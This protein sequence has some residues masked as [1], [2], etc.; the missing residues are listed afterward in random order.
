MSLVDVAGSLQELGPNTD[1]ARFAEMALPHLDAAYN[2]A[3]WL[4]RDPADA[5]DVV[6]E[7]ML[8][9]LR[10][11][12]S[13]RGGS[14]GKSWLLTI[15]RNTAIDWMRANRPAQ[16]MVPA[17]EDGDPFENIPAEGDDPEAA[18]IRIGDRQ[19]LDRL[20]AALPTD[21]RECLVLREMEELSYKEIAAVTG[22]PIGTV[23]SR[24]SRARLLMQ[25][26]LIRENAQ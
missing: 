11:F 24:L 10:F 25:R 22:V 21:Y 16:A 15:V 12:G 23:M 5:S 14:S 6:Q 7:S 8:R 2:L 19:Q 13:F 17:A 26:A 1:T 20:I 3:R 18:L 4:T 9:A